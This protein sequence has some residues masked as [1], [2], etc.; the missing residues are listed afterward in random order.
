MA[1]ESKDGWHRLSQRERAPLVQMS[2]RRILRKT[3]RTE[4]GSRPNIELNIV[5]SLER[6]I[7]VN[8]QMPEVI[9]GTNI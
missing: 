5:I 8:L 6:S 3:A 1:N 2:L 9:L 4:P 7:F